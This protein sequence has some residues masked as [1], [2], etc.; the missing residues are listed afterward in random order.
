MC[1]TV[2]TLSSLFY[3]GTNNKQWG[4]NIR[5]WYD[6]VLTSTNEVLTV[7]IIFAFVKAFTWYNGAN[8]ISLSTYNSYS[9]ECIQVLTL[10][11]LVYAGTNEKH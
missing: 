5:N 4:T 10:A 6:P 3:A 9:R 8:K 7:G 11:R 1:I 2:I